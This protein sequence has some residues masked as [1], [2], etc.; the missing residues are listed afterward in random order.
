MH[1]NSFVKKKKKLF[2]FPE[3][4]LSSFSFFLFCS[5]FLICSLLSSNPNTILLL[6]STS[7]IIVVHFFLWVAIRWVIWVFFFFFCCDQCLKE[8]VGS[9]SQ[10]SVWVTARSMFMGF[11]WWVRCWLW[12]DGGGFGCVDGGGWMRVLILVGLMV[13]VV[14]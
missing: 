11:C 2:S 5:L 12:V 6:T 7:H 8:E 9:G 10:R 4:S 14:G 13:V 1:Y 3:I